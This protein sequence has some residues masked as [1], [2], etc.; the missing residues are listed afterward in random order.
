MTIIHML[1]R[2]K[3]CQFT[4]ITP[5]IRNEML[6]VDDHQKTSVMI[7]ILPLDNTCNTP[8]I[9]TNI[10]LQLILLQRRKCRQLTIKSEVL[11][12]HDTKTNVPC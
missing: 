7:T 3:G 5:V 8:V 10:V 4:I 12:N 6:T 1:E 11:S 2:R 9:K